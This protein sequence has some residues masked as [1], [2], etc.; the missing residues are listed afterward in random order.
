MK[1]D[2]IT[3]D[4]EQTLGLI[5]ETS[6]EVALRLAVQCY[7]IDNSMS[8]DDILPQARKFKAWLDDPD[9]DDNGKETP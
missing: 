9:Q 4:G 2:Q 5:V 6:A 1:R 3:D 8:R 7:G